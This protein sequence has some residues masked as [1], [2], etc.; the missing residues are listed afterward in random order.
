[1]LSAAPLYVCVFVVTA[2]LWILR[3]APY[4]GWSGWLPNAGQDVG[5]ATVAL[6]ACLFL[7]LCPSGETAD[8]RDPNSPV[9]AAHRLLDWPTAARIPWGILINGGSSTGELLIKLEA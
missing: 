6:A 1:M 5:D 3:A 4:G 8:P 7:F 2:L 9:P